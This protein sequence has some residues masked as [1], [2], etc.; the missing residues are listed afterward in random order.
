MYIF[1]TLPG[2]YYKDCQTEC[3][4]ASTG[5]LRTIVVRTATQMLCKQTEEKKTPSSLCWNKKKYNDNAARQFI[6]VF[7]FFLDCQLVLQ[8]ML[9]IVNKQE[10]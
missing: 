9:E 5:E 2:T 10:L 1:L 7:I 3:K 6:S 8:L 4:F